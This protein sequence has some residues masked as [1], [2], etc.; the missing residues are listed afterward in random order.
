LLARGGITGNQV[1]FNVFYDI[2][3]GEFPMDY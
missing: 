3:I 2:F 1:T